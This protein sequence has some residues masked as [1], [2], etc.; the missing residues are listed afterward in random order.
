DRWEAEKQ[1]ASRQAAAQAVSRHASKAPPLLSSTAQGNLNTPPPVGPLTNHVLHITN[2]FALRLS[3]T[4]ASLP[5]LQ[6][7]PTAILLENAL[8]D[9]A[10]KTALAI[11]TNLLAQ[12]DPGTF[13]VQ[14]KGPI[15]NAFRAAIQGAGATVVSYIPNN[16]Y[17][18]RASQGI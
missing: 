9:T 13:I 1:L 18:V 4:S 15:D 8:I 16:A 6:R 7:S 10:S 17:L 14:A 12:G 11:P 3:N 2:R 5:E